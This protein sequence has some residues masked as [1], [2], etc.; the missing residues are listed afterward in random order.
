MTTTTAHDATREHAPT[1][2][3]VCFVLYGTTTRV[4][5]HVS[6]ALAQQTYVEY[7]LGFPCWVEAI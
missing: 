6:R 7:V 4:R 2:V 3:H 1:H 5:R